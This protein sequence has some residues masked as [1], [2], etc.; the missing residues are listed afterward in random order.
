MTQTIATSVIILFSAVIAGA[1]IQNNLVRKSTNT[2][3]LMLAFSAAYLLALS[4]LHILPEV[5]AS[6]EFDPGW[7]IL[8]GFILQI[9]LDYFSQG[10]EHGH[11]HHDHNESHKGNFLFIVM[12]ALW[13]HAFI[14][15]MPFGSDLEHIHHHHEHNHLFGHSLLIGISLHKITEGFVVAALLR[16]FH[17]TGVKLAMMISLFA[18]IAPLGAITNFCLISVL[19]SGVDHFTL[20]LLSVLIG[21]LLHVS[22]II[23]FENDQHHTFNRT[24]MLVIAAGIIAAALLH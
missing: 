20:P 14:E 4:L 16:S 17:Y 10:I 7:Y 12:G 2:F 18:L 15:G 5:F 24:K 21:I 11:S 9:I 23:L 8:G 22:T 1:L 13:I 3:K 6:P 19:E